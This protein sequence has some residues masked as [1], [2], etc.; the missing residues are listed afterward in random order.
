MIKRWY[1]HNNFSQSEIYII[2]TAMMGEGLEILEETEKAINFRAY[3]DWGRL[4]FW[5][6]KSCLMENETGQEREWR[7][8][9]HF[10]KNSK[11]KEV[12]T[13]EEE[14]RRRR[15]MKH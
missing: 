11:G 12:S 10:C 4:T 1:L 14:R 13:M 2:D 3:S 15:W 5:C 7:E 6:P 8:G 9:I